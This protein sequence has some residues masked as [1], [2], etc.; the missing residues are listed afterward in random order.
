MDIKGFPI[1]KTSKPV[2][3]LSKEVWGSSITMLERDFNYII[4][5]PNKKNNIIPVQ[6]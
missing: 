4:E 3:F 5:I 1:M 6:I 2:F